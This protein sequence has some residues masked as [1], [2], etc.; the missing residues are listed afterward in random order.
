MSNYLFFFENSNKM[1]IFIV[2]WLLLQYLTK[3]AYLELLIH[4]NLTRHL[5]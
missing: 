2:S 1:P 5:L 3:L 4:Y